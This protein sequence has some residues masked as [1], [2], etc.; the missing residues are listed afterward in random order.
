MT[1]LASVGESARG[2]SQT[3]GESPSTLEAGRVGRHAM[4]SPVYLHAID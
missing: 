2:G 1:G 4:R 3:S